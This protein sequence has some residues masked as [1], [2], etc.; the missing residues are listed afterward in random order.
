MS[1]KNGGFLK[2][3]WTHF[4]KSLVIYRTKDVYV[5]SDELGNKYYERRHGN[6]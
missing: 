3:T 5:G 6:V 1:S 4:K 2:Q